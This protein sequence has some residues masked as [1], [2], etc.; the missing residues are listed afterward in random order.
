[1]YRHKSFRDIL[2]GLAEH[3][4]HT[5]RCALGRGPMTYNYAFWSLN[6]V[7]FEVKKTRSSASTV[8]MGREEHHAQDPQPCRQAITGPIAS[9]S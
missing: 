3:P 1:M 5:A 9:F 6:E 2:G 8:A 4:V 7:G